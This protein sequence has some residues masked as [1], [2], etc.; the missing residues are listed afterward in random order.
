MFQADLHNFILWLVTHSEIPLSICSGVLSQ[1]EQNI[2]V[3]FWPQ[4]P[5]VSHSSLEEEAGGQ[6]Q[7]ICGAHH[8]DPSQWLL[9]SKEAPWEAVAQVLE[10]QGLR[11]CLPG[12]PLMAWEVEGVDLEVEELVW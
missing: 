9:Q 2:T 4:P 12:C 8:A 7:N 11:V 1:W 10:P 5:P 6:G 3:E